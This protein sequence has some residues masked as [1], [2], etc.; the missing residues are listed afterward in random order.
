MKWTRWFFMLSGLASSHKVGATVLSG[1]AT[2]AF[3]SPLGQVLIPF[4]CGFA[5]AVVVHLLREPVSVGW[6]AGSAVVSVMLGG[7][8]GP[9]VMDML[10]Y[11]EVA[12]Y[13]PYLLW[14]VSFLCA[15]SWPTFAPTIA[16]RAKVLINNVGP[17]GHATG[18]DDGRA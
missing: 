13:S 3:V 15:A 16:T 17:K 5:G 1:A 12:P 6:A 9:A 8:V 11:H 18:G 7:L 4:V 2:V 10:V 14:L